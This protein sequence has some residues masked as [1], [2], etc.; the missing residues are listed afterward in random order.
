MQELETRFTQCMNDDLNVSGA[1]GALFHFIKLSNP[2]VQSRQMDAAQK[3][4]IS[5]SL[6]SINAVLGI[7][8]MN[9]CPLTPEINRLIQEREQARQRKNWDEADAARQ[10][11]FKMGINVLDTAG[12]PVWE[13]VERN[14]TACAD[15]HGSDFSCCS[16]GKVVG[17]F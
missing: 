17:K 8:D 3:K 2:M 1:M 11:L 4:E 10:E 6:E 13:R 5:A 7:L 12:G 16:E 9:Q 14:C 15:A